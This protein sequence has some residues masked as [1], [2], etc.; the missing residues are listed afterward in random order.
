MLW[1]EINSG[2]ALDGMPPS[3]YFCKKRGRSDETP[4]GFT[5]S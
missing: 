5:F 1:L 3:K 2:I 4:I